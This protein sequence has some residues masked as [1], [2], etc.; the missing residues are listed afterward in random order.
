[1]AHFGSSWLDEP[2]D[3][4]RPMIGRNWLDETH[5]EYFI[6]EDGVYQKIE[7][8]RQLYDAID[9]NN[10]FTYDGENYNIKT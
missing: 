2:V 3:D 8:K 1:M 10:R 6:N 9:N 7:T 5:F 4:D